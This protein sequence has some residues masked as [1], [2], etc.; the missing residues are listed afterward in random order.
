MQPER[1]GRERPPGQVTVEEF[2]RHP[3]K[4]RVAA[5]CRQRT[6]RWTETAE[7][8][9]GQCRE[10]SCRFHRKTFLQVCRP[11]IATFR[12]GML[13]G[14]SGCR[15]Q[16]IFRRLKSKLL[17]LQAERFNS[18]RMGLTQRTQRTQRN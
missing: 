6:T 2:V 18:K 15:L 5:G 9:D 13:I 7:E 14:Q 4:G 1:R 10:G 11:T 3:R 12:T 17:P 8:T 16:Q